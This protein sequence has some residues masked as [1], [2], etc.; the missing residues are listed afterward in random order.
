MANNAYKI[1]GSYTKMHMSTGL[2]LSSKLHRISKSRRDWKRNP[3]CN[4][5]Y[6][7]VFLQWRIKV[8]LYS[9]YFLYVNYKCSVWMFD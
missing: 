2:S 5:P 3:G 4:T 6:S 8:F 1:L 9:N 7:N